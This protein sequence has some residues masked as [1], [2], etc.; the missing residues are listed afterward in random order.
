MLTEKACF[1]RFVDMLEI[2]QPE[3]LAQEASGVCE[4]AS[5]NV[6]E[7]PLSLWPNLSWADLVMNS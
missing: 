6:P 1:L 7:E 5:V 3:C 4:N 2:P